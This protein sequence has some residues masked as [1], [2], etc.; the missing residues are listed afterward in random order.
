MRIL[1]PGGGGHSEVLIP[2]SQ[3]LIEVSPSLHAPRNEDS[4]I[5]LLLL[6]MA[7]VMRTFCDMKHL[8]S[9]SRN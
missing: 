5:A 8:Q 2:S 1:Q 6:T 3:Q 7:A 4:Q 9:Y